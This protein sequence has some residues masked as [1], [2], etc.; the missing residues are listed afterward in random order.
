MTP[1]QVKVCTHSGALGALY[2]LKSNFVFVIFTG[3]YP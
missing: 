1:N 3:L 2:V